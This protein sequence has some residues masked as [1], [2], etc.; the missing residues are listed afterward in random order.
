MTT[1]PTRYVGVLTDDQTELGLLA[2][3]L[4][5]YKGTREILKYYI[6]SSPDAQMLQR[7]LAAPIVNITGIFDAG[8]EDRNDNERRLRRIF[9]STT[10]VYC[11]NFSKGTAVCLVPQHPAHAVN[12]SFW[13]SIDTFSLTGLQRGQTL[14]YAYPGAECTITGNGEVTT[15]YSPSEGIERNALR[16]KVADIGC[17]DL[18][19]CIF[20]GSNSVYFELDQTAHGLPL[21][22]YDFIIRVRSDDNPDPL[23]MEVSNEDVVG[24]WEEAHDSAAA[25]AFLCMI[26]HLGKLYAGGD[27]G[28]VY[29]SE[30]GTTWTTA[31]ATLQTKVRCF[32]VHDSCL[33][34]GTSNNG[35]IFKMESNGVWAEDYDLSNGETEVYA[36]HSAF[37][38]LYAGGNSS[39]IYRNASGSWA[40][41]DEIQSSFAT[42]IWSMASSAMNLILGT[43]GAGEARVIASYQGGTGWTRWIFTSYGTAMTAIKMVN[44]ELY[45]GDNSGWVYHVR[46][47]AEDSG[48]SSVHGIFSFWGLPHI[49]T[50]NL[51][52]LYVWTATNTLELV[53]DFETTDLYCGEVFGAHNYVGTGNTGKIYRSTDKVHV[54]RDIECNSGHTYNWFALP[55]EIKERD[56]GCTIRFKV[57]NTWGP[58]ESSTHVYMDV[59]AIV[60]K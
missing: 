2:L 20:A 46:H 23:T 43:T 53:N 50:S 42:V 6:A 52:K 18:S 4:D 34:A 17:I 35:K 29:V 32:E 47:D 33:Y 36:L 24:D 31:Y 57:T 48:Q 38:Y 58:G 10:D 1:Q 3:K 21:G 49:A 25:T 39:F 59:M 8:K 11:I 60:S 56:K 15:D 40:E 51:G 13:D 54:T 26:N 37:G 19:G 44:G 28:I 14:G 7:G 5:T 12:T 30:D 55:F 41:Y 16:L 9:A 45:A 27:N 22:T